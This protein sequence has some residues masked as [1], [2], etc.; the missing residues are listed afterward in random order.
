MS[1]SSGG[2]PE[3]KRWSSIVFSVM[4]STSR[5][6]LLED[7]ED[8]RV[9]ADSYSESEVC[10]AEVELESGAERETMSRMEVAISSR[11]V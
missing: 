8:T 4:D 2:L 6:V 10:A 1:R 7:E 3:V 9:E 11:E 5:G